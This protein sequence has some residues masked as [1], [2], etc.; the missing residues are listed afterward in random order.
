MIRFCQIKNLTIILKNSEFLR[1]FCHFSSLAL[2]YL[3]RRDEFS[4]TALFRVRTHSV[5]KYPRNP[6]L[7]EGESRFFADD[8]GRPGGVSG[9][10][11]L[12]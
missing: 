7:T 11:R 3:R 12:V 6:L 5:S 10:P 4:L 9:Y 2:G 8:T 1:H